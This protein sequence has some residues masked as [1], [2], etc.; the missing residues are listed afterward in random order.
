MYEISKMFKFSA[1]HHLGG[2]PVGHQCGRVH[3]HNY[4]VTVTLLSSALDVT[5]FVV[6]YGDLAPIKRMID[7]GYDHRDLNDRL[8]QPTAENLAR[9]FFDDIASLGEPW[10]GLLHRVTVSE[11]D[12]TTATYYP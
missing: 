5:G 10:C 12:T 9:Q 1:A 8:A 4:T 2:L 6:D 7:A 11:T 3:G